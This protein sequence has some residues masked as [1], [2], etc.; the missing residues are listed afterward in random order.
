MQHAHSGQNLNVFQDADVYRVVT[1][2]T[3]EQVYDAP[4]AAAAVQHAVDAMAGGGGV[5]LG[6]GEFA[7]EA[8]VLLRDRVW[9][10]GGGRGTQLRVASEVGVLA[11]GVKGALVSDVA[12][13]AA[14]EDARAG[15]VLDACGDCTVRDVFAARF[16]DYGVWVRNNSF[17]CTVRGCSL[18]GNGSANLFFDEL[19]RGSYGDFLPNL[20][21]HCVIY[22]GGKG[23]DCNRSIVLNIV[24]CL[25]YQTGAVAYHV[26]NTS[27]SVLISGCRSFQITG[28]A[29][30]VEGAHEFN[31]SSNIFCWHTEHG[32]HV[33][34]C[35]WG[36]ISG[37]E[38]IDT[39]S[40]NSGQKDTT[41]QVQDVTAEMPLYTGI[42]LEGV[43]GFN[44]SGNAIFNWPVAP[45]MAYGVREDAGSFGNSIVSNTINFYEHG[46]VLAE[47][48]ET[49]EAHNVGYR[50][51]PYQSPDAVGTT[52]QSFMTE[53]TE[54]LI[55]EM[56][57]Q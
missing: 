23:V 56:S 47:G 53:L 14:G 37:N 8:P 48:R 39:G 7:L 19:A 33:K 4:D 28:P 1:D 11:E 36:T 21:A 20:A 57:G 25:V 44:V 32:V 54:G 35:N 22:G 12:L 49:D 38:I 16:A 5:T 15:V 13:V 3:R 50:D 10:R 17:L 34:D 42:V 46:A 52:Y 43:Q 6:R 24:G 9:L 45:R 31:L 18:A 30:L 55:E 40:Y 2:M 51:K 26:R 41:T 29:V 27:N